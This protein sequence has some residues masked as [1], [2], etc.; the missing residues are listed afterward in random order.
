MTASLPERAPTATATSRIERALPF[1][2]VVVRSYN[3]IPTLCQLLQALLRQD[4]PHF[5]IVV[6]EQTASIP[7]SHAAEFHRLAGEPRVRVLRRPPLG[8][9]G[10]RNAGV[11]AAKGEVFVFIDDDDLPRDEAFI[12]KHIEAL[13][14]PSCLGVSGRLL[15]PSR[16]TEP[17]HPLLFAVTRTLSYDPLLKMPL[18]YAQHDRR[19]IPVQAI[20]GSNASLRRSAWQRFGGWDVDTS[21]EDEVSFCFRAMKGKQP[22]EYFAYDPRPV[23]IRNEDIAGGLDKRQMSLQRYQFEYLRFVHTIQWRYHPLRV[24][25]LYPLYLLAAYAMSVA[26]VW[27]HSRRYRSAPARAWVAIA[28]LLLL[29]VQVGKLLLGRLRMRLTPTG[30]RKRQLSA[31]SGGRHVG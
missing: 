7:D 24:L 29:P 3:R 6:V 2:S 11:E 27:V 25:C 22:H 19:C 26:W 12:S 31:K 17:F 10:A 15:D 9:A 16:A 1:V 30:R 21:I 18:T 23:L 28:M 8:G 13:E 5:E 4:Y 20:L 14:D